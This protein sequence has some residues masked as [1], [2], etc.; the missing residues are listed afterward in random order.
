MNRGILSGYHSLDNLIHGWKS[1]EVVVIGARPSV[2]KT[3]M[4]M[5][6]AR[7]AAI[8]DGVSAAYFSFGD[9]LLHIKSVIIGSSLGKGQLFF[10]DSDYSSVSQLRAGIE[11]Q[12]SRHNV[13]LVIIDSIQKIHQE[14]EDE[15]EVIRYGFDAQ[16]QELKNIATNLGISIIVLSTIGRNA[17]Y[18]G[19][20]LADLVY[21]CTSVESIADTILIA[22]RPGI[23]RNTECRLDDVSILVFQKGKGQ[24]GTITLTLD[25]ETLRLDDPGISR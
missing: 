18:R 22:D 15:E 25:R 1:G 2:G 21:Y 3:V 24:T 23:I 20:I 14:D 4:A 16:L 9:P 10:D 12:V 7:F 17:A 5:H 11:E 8:E 6:M 19:A 13:R